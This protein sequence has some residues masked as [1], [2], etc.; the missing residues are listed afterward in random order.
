MD[1][2][3]TRAQQR[4]LARLESLEASGEVVGGW[5]LGLTSGGS[6]DA[7]GPGIRPFGFILAS[8]VLADGATLD[9]ARVGSG[10]IEN[11]V[12]FVVGSDVTAPVSA[13]SVRAHIEAVAPAFEI[14][15]RRIPASAPPAER[16]EDGLA[17]WGIVVGTPRPIPR[18]WQPDALTVTLCHD[19]EVVEAVAARGH[20]D[21]HFD[22][23][24]RLANRLLEF[25]RH[26]K[27]GE[28]LITGAYG[29]QSQPDA[30]LWSGDFG[31]ELGSVSLSIGT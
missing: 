19:G 3:L 8:R 21:D 30:G 12:C 7:F 14:N 17:N 22:S 23:L 1:Q 10:G 25:G 29:R 6:R 18:D 16:I 13:D 24:A 27:A 20:I 4:Q 2:E 28:R 5:K 31:P 26:L 15:Q 9:W 11:E